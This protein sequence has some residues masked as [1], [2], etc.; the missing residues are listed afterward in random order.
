MH[1]HRILDEYFINFF[2]CAYQNT[3]KQ[4]EHLLR[5]QKC[6][7][8]WSIYVVKEKDENILFAMNSCNI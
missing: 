4:I 6:I 2:V 3:A 5:E 8:L 7:S 1:Q